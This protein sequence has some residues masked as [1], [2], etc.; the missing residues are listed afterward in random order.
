MVHG[1]VAFIP[2]ESAQSSASAWYTAEWNGKHYIAAFHWTEKKELLSLDM[3]RAG[4][5][6][7]KRYRDLW[8][9]TEFAGEQGILKWTAEGCDALL[10]KELLSLDME[11]AGLDEKKRYRDLWSGTEFAGEQ[12]ILK[13]T[14]EGCDALLLKEI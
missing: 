2:V 13:W 10:L 6:E 7:K 1:R 5:D 14:A 12:G 3:E 11:R 9:G 8:S 4:L